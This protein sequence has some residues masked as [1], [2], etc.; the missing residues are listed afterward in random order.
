MKSTWEET[1]LRSITSAVTLSLD[2]MIAD[3]VHSFLAIL[4]K[5]L[6]L[7]STSCATSSFSSTSQTPSVASTRNSSSASRTFSIISG[8]HVIKGCKLTSPMALCHCRRWWLE[9]DDIQ[10]TYLDT[11]STPSTLQRPQCFKVPPNRRIRLSSSFLSGR[12]SIDMVRTL[13]PFC[14]ITARESPASQIQQH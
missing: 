3:S 12:W 14:T 10:W 5:S 8:S 7:L 6:A 1:Y 13:P 2:P 4:M 9:C 11:A